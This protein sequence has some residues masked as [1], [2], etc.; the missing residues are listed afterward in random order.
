MYQQPYQPNA[1]IITEPNIKNSEQSFVFN[2]TLAKAIV[3]YASAVSYF[4]HIFLSVPWVLGPCLVSSCI[5]VRTLQMLSSMVESLSLRKLLDIVKPKLRFPEIFSFEGV[6]DGPNS[7]VHMDMLKMQ[8][9]DSSKISK[10][11]SV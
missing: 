11:Y 6:Y 9:L 10:K 1:L 2:Y 7:Y 5:I 8:R 3:E 4:L